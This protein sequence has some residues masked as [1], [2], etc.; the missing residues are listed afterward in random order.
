MFTHREKELLKNNIEESISVL[1][2][3]LDAGTTEGNLRQKIEDELI[4][5]VSVLNKLNYTKS[6]KIGISKK[7]RVLIVD[8]V[9]S[10]RK[11]HA[12]YFAECGFRN[13]RTAEDGLQAYKQL[14][15]AHEAGEP[16][17]LVVSDWEM[18]KVTGLDLL[19]K[20]RM[21][22][23]LW[24]IPFFLITSLGEKKH[25]LSAINAGVTGYMVKPV[26]QAIVNQKFA[27]FLN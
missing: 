23:H 19:K 9:Q 16:F 7:A 25:I 13:I 22:R 24:N 12:H 20:V 6:S 5:L 21:D 27:E 1:R 26:S 10:M 2:E 15:R 11:V 18:P 14:R 4:A 8:D 3:R 17:D